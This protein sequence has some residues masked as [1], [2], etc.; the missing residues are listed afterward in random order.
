M[1]E[2]FEKELDFVVFEKNLYKVKF[3]I[4]RGYGGLYYDDTRN[5]M[6]EDMCNY[7]NGA[8]R[9]Y[10]EMNKSESVY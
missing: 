4:N 6:R 5:P 9:C 10:K 3:D 1:H 2:K 7:L 8:W